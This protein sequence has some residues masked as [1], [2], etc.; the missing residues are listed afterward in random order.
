MLVCCVGLRSM[1]SVQAKTKQ[2]PSFLYTSPPPPPPPAPVPGSEGPSPR[3]STCPLDVL[4]GAGGLLRT[5]LLSTG[6]TVPHTASLSP[7]SFLAAAEEA[8]AF[9]ASFILSATACLAL[10]LA[11]LGNA[12]PSRG[13]RYWS[14]LEEEAEREALSAMAASRR[15]SS[16]SSFNDGLLLL[17]PLLLPLTLLLLPLTLLLLPLTLL[18]LPSA[19]ALA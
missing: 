15:A 3:P 5:F 16:S 12:P 2:Q 19:S 6:R 10:M 14:R 1:H 11:W 13:M 7:S 8:R 4:G 17:L 9:C 18:L